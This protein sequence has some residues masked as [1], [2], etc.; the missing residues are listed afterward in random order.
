MLDAIPH[1]DCV[2]LLHGLGRTA[3]SMSWLARDFRLDGYFVVNQGYRSRSASLER[4]APRIQISIDRC[5]TARP[6]GKIHF[7]THSMGGILLRQYFANV[8][9]AGTFSALDY[10][11][12]VL[13][14]PPNQG[15]EIVDDWG[16]RWWFKMIMGEAGSSLG[17]DPSSKPNLLPTLPIQF[18]VIAGNTGKIGTRWFGLTPSFQRSNDG[19]VAVDSAKLAGMHAFVETAV[20]H[21]MLPIS[22][23]SRKLVRHYLKHG[24]WS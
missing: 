6:Q 20:G 22:A 8:Q 24:R 18:A 10:G 3:M 1:Q 15:S 12:A 14:G 17:S 4:L 2:V 7:V 23:T 16:K 13:L 19:K 9:Q 11:R 21:T 5:R